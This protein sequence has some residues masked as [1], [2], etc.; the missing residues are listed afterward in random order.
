MNN[1]L[2]KPKIQMRLMIS[3]DIYI[4]LKGKKR[5]LYSRHK[6]LTCFTAASTISYH[7]EYKRITRKEK[8][9]RIIGK[10]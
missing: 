9:E 1:K 10:F 3:N 4:D 8:R 7:I 6:K 2:K 5:L